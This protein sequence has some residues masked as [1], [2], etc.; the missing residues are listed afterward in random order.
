M[1]QSLVNV[2]QKLRQINFMDGVQN[3]SVRGGGRGDGR[4]QLALVAGRSD[5]RRVKK[6]IQDI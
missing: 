4:S 3:R 1:C 5:K 2:V 6:A